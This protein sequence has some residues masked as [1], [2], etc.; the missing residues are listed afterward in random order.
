MSTVIRTGEPATGR[1]AEYER[2]S[3]MRSE[4][5]KT[6]GSRGPTHRARVG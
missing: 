3:A 2:I 4:V 1:R 5:V 6:F